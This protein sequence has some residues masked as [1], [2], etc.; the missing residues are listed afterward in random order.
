MSNAMPRVLCRWM[1]GGVFLGLT[2]AD[3]VAAPAPVVPDIEVPAVVLEPPVPTTAVSGGDEVLDLANIVRS[4][5]KGITTVQEAPAIVTVVTADEIRDRQFHDFQQIIDTIPGW[6]RIGFWYS[7]IQSALVRGQLQSVLLLH[8]GL[9][10]FDPFVNLPVLSRAL[11]LEMVKRVEVITG[12]GGVL[13]GS[14]SLLGIINVITKDAEDLEGIEVGGSLG[15]GIGDRRAARAYALAGA[16]NIA[17]TKL[18]GL[19]HASVETYHGAGLAM[20]V[21]FYQTPTPQPAS[22]AVYGPL[23]TTDPKRSVVVHLDGKLAYDKLQFR[24]QFPFGR[25]EIPAGLSAQPVRNRVDPN[26]PLGIARNNRFDQYDRY[27]VLEYRT[28]FAGDRAGVTTHAYLIQFVRHFYSLAGIAPSATLPGGLGLDIDLTSQRAGAVIDGDLEL[29]RPL[30]L[31]YGAEV[32]REW[33]ATTNGR[34]GTNAGTEA[35]FHAPYDVTRLPILCPR[36]YEGGALVPVAKCPLTSAFDADRVVLGAYV[37]PQYRPTPKLIFDAG[38]RVSVAPS[39]LGSLSYKA[40]PSFGGAIVWN[41][42]PNWHL[43]LNY[44][45]GFRPPTFNATQANGSAVQIGGNPSLLVE[46]SRAAQAEINARIFKGD[47]RIRELSFR[48]DASYTRLANLVQIETGKYNNTGERGLASAE[49]L[50]KL[51]I[52]GGHRVE[53]GYTYL[54][55]ST[56]DRGPLRTMPEHWFNLATVWSLL[57]KSLIATTNLRI[58][59]AAEDPNR[60]VEHRGIAYDASGEPMGTVTS[61]AT[62]LVLDRLAPFAD[63]S[64][65]VQYMPTPRLAIRASVYNA[66]FSHAYQPD[67]FA[68]YAPRLEYVPN[69]YEGIRAYLSASLQY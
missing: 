29:A 13:W 64:A 23:T 41:F 9:S 20:P 66:L 31:L 34:T 30:R 36:Q 24:W 15:D 3:G 12:P 2:I 47:R 19:A 17:G 33:M 54:R 48:F 56:T 69:P 55:G 18:K 49:F 65:S 37:N 25:A 52:A 4:A 46:Q 51:F 39:A 57:P 26:D 40:N 67:A 10:L 7:A 45:E 16:S 58:T 28:R 43:K 1:A 21:V 60:L 61:A 22:P 42:I 35:R 6:S 62:D 8:D 32:S 5:A 27:G 68:D 11:P 50:G 63:L 44:T 14:N 59:G 38:A 53:L